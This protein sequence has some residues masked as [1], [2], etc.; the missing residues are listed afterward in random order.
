MA[1]LGSLAPELTKMI[2]EQLDNWDSISRHRLALVS[3]TL[4]ANLYAT[5]GRPPRM[6][7]AE[8]VQF[9]EFERRAP[10]CPISLPCPICATLLPPTSFIDN[11]ARKTVRGSRCRLACGIRTGTYQKVSF[12]LGGILSFA[13]GGCRQA[14]PLP[15]EDSCVEN[16]IW[17]NSQRHQSPSDLPGNVPSAT[18]VAAATADPVGVSSVGMRWCRACWRQRTTTVRLARA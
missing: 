14:M 12:K 7:R 4:Y 17:R 8:W 10:H 1:K 6:T 16:I 3:R 11:H 9:N 15:L 18:V 13:C 2:A 5:P